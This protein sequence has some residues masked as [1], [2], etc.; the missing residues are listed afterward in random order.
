MMSFSARQHV[1]LGLFGLIMGF[2]LHRIGFSDF[3]EV[4]RLF[5]LADFRLFFTF[6][7][8]VAL[9]MVGFAVLARGKHIASKPYHRGSITGGMMF[10]AG[11]AVTGACPSVVLIHIGEGKLAALAT[12]VGIVVGVFAYSKLKPKYFRWTSGACE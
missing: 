10:G 3:N 1:F 5:V 11:W 12:A 7:G 4:H 2:C 6:L 9:A 8:A